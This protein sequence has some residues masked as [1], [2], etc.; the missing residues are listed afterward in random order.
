MLSAWQRSHPPQL[1]QAFI[2][3]VQLLILAVSVAILVGVMRNQH[4]V[5]G[6]VS[7]RYGCCADGKTSKADAAG[8]NCA[9]AVGGCA[10]TRFGCCP[11]SSIARADSEGT[12]CYS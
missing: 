12:N 3:I 11:G 6:C 4:S 1:M 8:S 7:T 2:L 9:H 5:G 10:S